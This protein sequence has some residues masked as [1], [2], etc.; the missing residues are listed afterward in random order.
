[1]LNN[2]YTIYSLFYSMLVV[3]VFF[4]KD[5]I[6]SFETKT[7]GWLLILN[8][9][10]ILTAIICFFTILCRNQI[11]VINDI[12][13]KSL[14]VAFFLWLYVFTIYIFSLAKIKINY[15]GKT[16]IAFSL[17][18]T[19]IVS[20]LIFI[21][22][23]H[24]YGEGRVAY[25][26]GPSANVVFFAAGFLILTWIIVS[27]INFKKINKK[28]YLPV[29]MFLCLGVIVVVIQ[30]MIP[31]LLLLTALETFVTIL[32]YFTIEN[33]DVKMIAQVTAAKIQADKANKAKSDFLSSMSH[34]IRTP[35]NAIVGF[36]ECI[37]QENDIEACYDDAND[38]I[39]ASQNL[40]E[41]VNGI[42]DI[43]KI[44]ANKMEIVVTNYKPKPIFENIAKLVST[45]IGEK[46]IELN[47]NITDDLPDV[48][49][50]DAGKLKQVTTNILTNAV[51]YTEHG[52]INFDVKCINTN[53][54]SKI[55]ISVADTGR[56]IKPEQMNKLFKKFERLDEDKNTTTEGTGLGLAITKNLVEMM[57]GT[58]S[59][60]SR[61]GEGSTFTI[62]LKQKIITDKEEQAKLNQS[63]YDIPAI[64]LAGS[65]VLI[66]DD[67]KL[68]LKVCTKLLAPYSLNI[69][70]ALSGFECLDLLKSGNK[71]DLILLDDMMPKMSGTETYGKLKTEIE[72]FNT[73]VVVLTANA[74]AGMKD[75][76]MEAGFDDYLA[77]P[78]EKPELHRVLMKYL[79]NVKKDPVPQIPKDDVEKVDLTGK[80]IL[81][82]DDNKLNLKVAENVLKEYNP[83]I[84]TTNSG[85][86]CL[87]VLSKNTFD[88]ILMDD[89]MPQLSGT[90]TMQM[91]RKDPNFKMPIVVL[92]ANAI[93]GARES[94]IKAGF[95]DYLSKP[96]DKKELVRVLKTFIP[97]DNEEK[98]IIE[99]PTETIND[100]VEALE[101]D[102]YYHTCK[103]LEENGVDVDA[104]LKYLGSLDMY[105]DT[106]N[107]F[108]KDITNRVVRLNQYKVS[109]NMNN[110]AIEVHALKSDCKYLGLTKLTELAT[111]HESKSKENDIDYVNNNFDELMKEISRVVAVLKKYV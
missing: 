74:I 21:L 81:L 72:G 10:N 8:L 34:E 35:L 5:R 111:N 75:K 32:M 89:M 65:K 19:L 31:E 100:E 50:G 29:L 101:D 40:L 76:Y 105:D 4:S 57:G 33:P 68:N 73:P 106:A 103:Y 94:Y 42:L 82:V 49:S 26:Y 30:R 79:N 91:L 43:S 2:D 102:Y 86:E 51:K 44:E 53:D 14:L 47:V 36:S 37:K 11:P 99:E 38:I 13:S 61:Y 58:V 25:S 27:I 66:V 97:L 63:Y 71:F 1:M 15:T 62:C 59:V 78:I 90:Q 69:T 93:V 110:Y 107:D 88:L 80:T 48:L 95:D 77:K 67:N 52:Y 28:Q 60:Q 41:I 92:T 23:L 24:Y 18:V 64:N 7:Y 9:I 109:S 55:I 85:Q 17:I 83:V 98:I 54:E 16:F 20:T 22:P 3:I 56:G 87:D 96:I 6:K 45:R 104:S 46:P 84:T 70:T 39:M 12:V 108:L